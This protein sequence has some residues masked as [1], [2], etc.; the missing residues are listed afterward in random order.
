[1]VYFTSDTHFGTPIPIRYRKPPYHTHEEWN[2]YIIARW[3]ETVGPDDTVIH[4]GDVGF[5]NKEDFMRTM[6]RLPGKKIL[7]KGNNDVWAGIDPEVDS[8]FAGIYDYLEI[9]YE[10]Y[11][12]ILC[13][14]P[15]L[16]WNRSRLGSLHMYE[17]IHIREVSGIPFRIS[18]SYHVGTDENDHTPQTLQQLFDRWGKPK[19]SPLQPKWML[20][21]SNFLKLD[22]HEITDFVEKGLVTPETLFVD[23]PYKLDQAEYLKFRESLERYEQGE[24]EA[25]EPLGVIGIDPMFILPDS[26]I[27]TPEFAKDADARVRAFM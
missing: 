11:F 14:Y 25:I 27:F 1:M 22:D 16:S 18:N 12:I 3:Q 15:M 19:V 20:A 17:H 24:L 2:E 10:G 13:H 23:S 7:V 4:L 6:Q 9:W 21:H 26:T 8:C 5:I